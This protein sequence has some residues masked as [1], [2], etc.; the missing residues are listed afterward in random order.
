L[1]WS[2][3]YVSKLYSS[4]T[5]TDVTRGVPRGYDPFFEMDGTLTFDLDRR[6]S[7]FI[8]ATNILDRDYFQYYRARGRTVSAGVRLRVF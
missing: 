2:G 7:L 5:N 8:D 6:A 3:R 4:D 1:A